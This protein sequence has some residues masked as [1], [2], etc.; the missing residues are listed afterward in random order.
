MRIS[1]RRQNQRGNA[2]IESA[3][4]LGLFVFVLVGIVDFAQILHVHQS[5]VER[6]RSVARTAVVQNLTVE[7]IRDRIVYGQSM[8]IR[9]EAGLMPAGFM[10]L[11]R[12]HV[13]VEILDRTYSEQRL[14]VDV[15]GVPIIILSPLMAGQGKN[16]PL[17]ITI[18]LEEP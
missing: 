1:S 9:T 11:R 15:N 16:L 6:V 3:L 14:V 4:V 7:E 10:G 13:T 5:L 2:L 17:R 12:E 8:D 18:P